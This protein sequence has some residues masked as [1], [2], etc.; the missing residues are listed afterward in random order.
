M[1]TIEEIRNE[2]LKLL[3]KEK[4]EGKQVRFAEAIGMARSLV[5]RMV[6]DDVYYHKP[7]GSDVAR[8]IEHELF[9]PRGWMDNAQVQGDGLAE[10]IANLS[11]HQQLLIANLV[12]ELE[13]NPD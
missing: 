4:F 5:S 8:K 11:N 1:K 3:L 2:N 6:R 7:M 12:E 10:S 9:L 13:K